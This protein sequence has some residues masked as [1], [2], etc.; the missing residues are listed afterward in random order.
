MKTNVKYT[1]VR[2]VVNE[3]KRT[4]VCI[5]NW[6]VPFNCLLS[7]DFVICNNNIHR[8]L[9]ENDGE[10]GENSFEFESIGIAKLNDNDNFDV[11]FGKH[12]AL[13]RAQRHA[14]KI[15][16]NLYNVIYKNILHYAKIMKN[17][18]YNCYASSE[19]CNNHI[20]ELIDNKYK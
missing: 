14:F 5:L 1:N 18:M 2:Y 11:E 16:K 19:T 4:V 12:L 9:S 15:A 8:F 3:E 10:I 17:K 7:E 6:D 13:T 20:N